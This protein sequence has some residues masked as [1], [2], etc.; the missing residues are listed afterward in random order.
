[1]QEHHNVRNHNEKR[2]AKVIEIDLPVF[3]PSSGLVGKPTP[4]VRIKFFSD[5]T[6]FSVLFT[7][8][9]SLKTDYSSLGLICGMEL[10]F[11]LS[12]NTYA[13]MT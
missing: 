4:M 6:V 7:D 1:M 11:D 12:W 5:F 8:G 3:L 13:A 9:V 2:A 10:L